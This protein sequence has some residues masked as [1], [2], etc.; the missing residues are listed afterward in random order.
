MKIQ[1]G[2][3]FRKY[4]PH[5]LA[6]LLLP[7]LLI[8]LWVLQ[9]D[10]QITSQF[11]GRR[12]TLPAKVYA[13]PLELYAGQP[14]SS[15]EL[16]TELQRL[17]YQS[18]L[19]VNHPGSFQRLSDRIN[20]VARPFRFM[21]E[22][23]AEQV[24][25]IAFKDNHVEKLWDNKGQDIPIFRLDPLLIGSIFPIHGEDR[26]IVTPQEVPPLLPAALKA[27]E[28]RRFD[29]HIGVDPWGI[30][31]ALWIDIRHGHFDQGGSTLTQQLVRSY[32]LNNQQT[33]SRKITEAV[34]AILL[35]AHFDK[36]DLMNSYINEIH[37]GQDGDRA[38]HGFGL[39]SEF[40]F[41]KPLHEL[42]L[43]EIALLV[44]EVR[45]ASYYNPRKHAD[46]ALA[47][48]NLILDL[49]AQNNLISTDDANHAKA[50]PLGLINGSGATSN[51]YP[52]FL[53]FVRRTL[54]R[55]Y[56]EA[57]LTEAG[58][59]IFTTLD[60]R[61]Q[62]R[63]EIALASELTRLDKISRHKDQALEGA[64][65][66]ASSHSGEVNAIV[67]GRQV[68]FSG[69]NRALDAK[70]SIGSLAKPVV[71]LTAIESGRYNA[72]TI[73]DD[74]PITVKLSE[75]T[76]WTPQ[77]FDHN[78]NGPVPM[79]RAL[80]QSLNLATVHIGMDIGVN[81]VADQF[82]QLGL[83]QRPEANPAIL[84]GAVNATPIDVTQMYNTFANDGFRTPLRAVHA[85][86]DEKGQPLK[87][88]SLE[89]S[90]AAD[91]VAIYQ[92]N[93]MMV[94]A[95]NRGTAAAARS[96][97]NNLVVAGKTGT[98]SDYRDNWFAGFSGS[99]V[100]VVWVGYDDNASTGLSASSAALPVWAQVMSGIE[101]TPWEQPLPE[102]ISETMIDFATGAGVNEQ[103]ATDGLKVAVPQGTQ[104]VMKEG[105]TAIH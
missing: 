95:V 8:G 38:V 29:S 70:R 23:R 4:W 91:P 7:I 97:L 80:A 2:N 13:Q 48:R 24:L 83:G 42:Q 88:F 14:L 99:H 90:Q 105:C 74:V 78:A 102:G 22:N 85:V 21:D 27:V 54:H 61:I 30:L 34:M 37:L 26:I 93:R 82:T 51:Y 17:G 73:V 92:V 98:T 96:K 44:T 59:T 65:I 53:D 46:R 84:L 57:D 47:R 89:V 16:Q 62:K 64:V 79:V 19:Q 71:Y 58:L 9:L 103:C 101:T 10:H 41:G 33:L 52:A 56:K 50:M 68:N 86:V 32:F 43:H 28:D 94:V 15:D 20:L 40:Y 75:K 1:F 36:A 45:S 55:D 66:V 3:F 6:V 60:P 11:E 63:A 69:F 18:V 72:S 67:G 104:S 81:K 35:E 77:N 100:A 31:R 12:W 87:A 39:A 25:T 5:L 76:S 49:L